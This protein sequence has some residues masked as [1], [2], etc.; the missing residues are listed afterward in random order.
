MNPL[1]SASPDLKYYKTDIFIP[2]DTIEDFLPLNQLDFEEL[3]DGGVLLSGSSFL[4]EGY[5]VC[6]KNSRFDFVLMVTGGSGICSIE[7]SWRILRRGDVFTAPTRTAQLYGT[8]GEWQIIWFHIRQGSALSFVGNPV[9]ISN[10]QVVEAMEAAYQGILNEHKQFSLYKSVIPHYCRIIRQKVQDVFSD[11]HADGCCDPRELA[12]QM[13]KHRI[14]QDIDHAWSVSELAELVHVSPSH[15]YKV[16]QKHMNCSPLDYVRSVKM[17]WGK[18]M[19]VH[20]DFSFQQIAVQLG[21]D[22]AYSFSKAFKKVFGRSPSY[23]R[24]SV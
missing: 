16:T 21:Y 12:V 13:M 7:G 5:R 24:K 1:M 17:E 3:N 18:E 15:L 2:E 10:L 22:N 9:I 20:S 8:D 19:V 4:T 23:F 11:V 6:R 14:K